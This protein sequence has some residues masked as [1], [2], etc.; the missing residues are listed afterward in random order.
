MKTGAILINTARGACV[1]AA[2]LAVALASGKL[3]GAGID[4]YPEEPVRA[5]SPLLTAPHIV[6]APH[7]GA[8]TA[9]NMDRIGT[10]A[11]G[12]IADLAA[13]KLA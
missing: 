13:G 11:E 10:I 8:S 5:D 1:N 2:D 4:V 7:L 6:L 3:A 9:E 12:I